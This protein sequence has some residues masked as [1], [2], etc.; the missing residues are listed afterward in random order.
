MGRR[1]SRMKKFDPA[2]ISKLSNIIKDKSEDNK[3]RRNLLMNRVRTGSSNE[4]YRYNSGWVTN[5]K[6]LE[7]KADKELYQTFHTS[8]LSI[9]KRSTERFEPI[10]DIKHKEMIKQMGTKTG[11]DN[12]KTSSI[13]IEYST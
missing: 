7:R 3:P 12:Y 8:I 6:A 10:N 2:R 11:M 13:S 1:N 4:A 5:K 9:P